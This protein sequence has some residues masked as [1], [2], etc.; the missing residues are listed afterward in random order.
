M[1]RG[2]RIVKFADREVTYRSM[3]ELVQLEDRIRA[4]LAETTS[5]PK[6]FFPVTSKGL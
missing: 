4:E 6:Q 3:A 5:Q 2:E 1:L